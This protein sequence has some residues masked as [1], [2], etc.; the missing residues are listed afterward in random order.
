[1]GFEY[2]PLFPL[3]KDNTPYRKLTQE[4]VQLERFGQH[5][6]LW[7]EREALRYLAEQ[8]MSD[9]NH[10]LRPSHLAQLAKIPLDPEATENDKFV[11]LDLLKNAN[12]A[13]GG[14]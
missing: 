13:A 12:I 14:A 5:E 3:G 4:G 9:I 2:H 7:V 6:F 10:F 1:M 11:A 8:A